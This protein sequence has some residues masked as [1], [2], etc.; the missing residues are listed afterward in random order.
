[1]NNLRFLLPT[2][3][4]MLGM[5]T[6]VGWALGIATLQHGFPLSAAMSPATAAGIML[7]G[8]ESLIPCNRADESLISR[9]GQIVIWGVIVASILKLGGV[10]LGTAFA[11]DPEFS[12][13]RSNEMS[14]DTALC[15]L[16]LGTAKQINQSQLK[17]RISIS[18]TLAVACALPP[19]L[20]IIGHAYDVKNFSG[21]GS[22]R[23]MTFSSAAALLFLSMAVLFA[24]P[25]KGY[26]RYLTSNGPSG[27]I[28]LILFPATFIVPF[29][30]GITSLTAQRA[31]IFDSAF[32]H[33][34]SVI[35]DVAIFYI[36]S[37][38]CVRS[39]FITDL[40]RQRAEAGQLDSENFATSVMD[41]ASSMIAVSNAEGVILKANDTW[42]RFA[43]EPGNE[44]NKLVPQVEVGDNYLEICQACKGQS[45][46]HGLDAFDGIRAVL[47]GRLHTFN[48]EYSCHSP[49]RMRWF[50]MTVAPLG[51]LLHGVVITHADISERKLLEEELQ[52]AASVY[53]NS[54]EAM[55]VTDE[56]NRIMAVNSAF[57]A[58]TGYTAD[59]VLGK[60]PGMLKSGQHD[61]EFYRAM[62]N[63]LNTTGHWQGEI[64]NRHK[65]GN[66][67]VEWITINTI[68]NDDGTV[69][70]RVALFS[71]I[72]EWKNAQTQIWM[73]ANYDSLTELP[74]RRLFHDR[75]EQEIRKAQRDQFLIALLFIDIDH[76]KEVNDTLGHD[77]GDLLLI[78]ASGRVRKCVRDYDTLARLGG[79]EF[80]VILPELH[81]PSDIGRI[82]Q[83]IID[84]LSE[85]FMLDD[86]EA[87]VSASVGIALYPDD[88]GNVT[89][90]IKHADQA[91]YSAKNSGRGCFQFFT[92]AMQK[93]SE[94]QMRLTGDLRHAL[95][96][97]QFEVYYQPIVDLATGRIHKAEALLRWKHPIHGFISPAEF[98][99]IAENTGT[100]NEI[101]N[102]VFMQAAQQVKKL[103][104]DFAG[105]F[106]ISINKSPV[107]FLG[108]ESTHNHWIEKI[109][110][111]G[112]PG[113]SVVIEITEGFLMSADTKIT[114]KLLKFRDAGIQVAI[115]DF[116]TGYSALA[117]L[118][119][120]DIDFLKIDQ[121]FI[122][123]LSPE[124][125][126]FALCEAIVVMAHKLGLKVI[127]EGVETGQQQDLL[128]QIGCDYG[129]GYLY[130]QP[131][132]AKAFEKLLEI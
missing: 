73:Q 94:Q 67:F 128:L 19:L 65:D 76:F 120:F 112:L 41:S 92:P 117:Y 79:D 24:Y 124:S 64:W 54:S 80:T 36:L 86:R 11:T 119:K 27:K 13:L 62:W 100:I 39:L 122:R 68:R 71:D 74:N 102:W 18:Q 72:T 32:D 77:M 1:M 81:D 70:R 56:N 31:G 30:L 4:L 66:V 99:P 12:S 104:T 14:E 47:D 111:L 105:D 114:D 22:L 45:S 52:L 61:T 51:F 106:Q 49:D 75:L 127:A 23:S 88:G 60:N 78:E 53:K 43:L 131:V 34:L 96:A 121:S 35:L 95:D 130:S 63:A 98:I 108:D 110:A 6:L 87:F 55:V 90:L 40:H 8:F 16:M 109:C 15:F 129:Q 2:V 118:K 28:A 57:A 91:M 89:D 20:V 103:R 69:H 25:D 115:D 85:P 46:D 48:L 93:A 97:D 29:L 113:N 38:I 33:T 125:Q 9:I 21:I 107:Q 132:P 17:E 10:M 83:N 26:M 3:P 5:L 37:F 116:G 59:E 7:L 58:M 123:N 101:G 84:R 50:S 44:L 42:R 126:D 82:A